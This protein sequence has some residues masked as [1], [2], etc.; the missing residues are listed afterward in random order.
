MRRFDMIFFPQQDW[1]RSLI[2]PL[3]RDVA[4]DDTTLTG[5]LLPVRF[6]SILQYPLPSNPYAT[7]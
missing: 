4:K 7:K 5:I 2:M 3:R 6:M 1:I